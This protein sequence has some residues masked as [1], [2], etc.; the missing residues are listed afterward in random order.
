M[1]EAVLFLCHF[2]NDDVLA[3]FEKLEKDLA[4]Y[5]DVFWALQCDDDTVLKEL[6]RRNIN[7]FGFSLDDLNT[8]GY[9]PIAETLVPGSLH[10]IPLYF[11]KCHLEYDYYWLIEYDV[12]FTGNWKTLISAFEEENA[13]LLASHV[14]KYGEN[15]TSW[16]WWQSL[17]LGVYDHPPLEKAVKSFNP[18]CRLS[19]KSLLFLDEVLRNDGY[20][21]HCEVLLAT[22]LYNHGFNICDIGGNGTFTPQ[23]LRNQFYIEDKG[24]NSSTMRW[25]PAYLSKE[26]NELGIT[27]R[28]FHPVK[29]SLHELLAETV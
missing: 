1:R 22:L 18:I 6:Q 29:T 7:L 12:V 4:G 5:C 16:T 2:V 19:H 25:R 23:R 9:S 20:K 14:E 17:S 15:N 24:I 13:D 8:L 3:R 27:N 26:V 10:F 21:G 28:L 11:C